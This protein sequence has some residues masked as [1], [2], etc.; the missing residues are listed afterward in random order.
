MLTLT[1]LL[2]SVARLRATEVERQTGWPAYLLL[3]TVNVTDELLDT[4]HINVRIDSDGV[5]D[6]CLDGD[7]SVPSITAD[8]R[9]EA[10]DFVRTLARISMTHLARGLGVSRPTAYKYYLEGV[11][12]D[13]VFELIGEPE[14]SYRG[15]ILY[16]AET[17]P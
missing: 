13:K 15:N 14:V 8:W 7:L 1:N 12:D 16:E 4:L 5:F 11:P 3:N 6:F 2:T 17:G 10:A 9:A